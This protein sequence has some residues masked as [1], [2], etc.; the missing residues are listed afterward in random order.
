M[1]GDKRNTS[2]VVA[3]IASMTFGAVALLAL[4]KRLVPGKPSFRGSTLLM[5]EREMRVREVE[6][7]YARTADDV[8]ALSVDLEGSDSV[9]VID[10]AGEP[11]WQQAGPRIQLVLI[12]TDGDT[13]GDAQKRTLLGALGTLNQA[14]GM[15]L[16]PVRLTAG[17][18]DRVTAD[19]PAQARDLRLLLERKGIIK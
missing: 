6:V 5:A 13:L 19:L 15:E 7:N 4:E 3:L 14:S 16:V 8:P 18:D 10:T 11:H 17:S 1:K 12:G 2:V 9:C